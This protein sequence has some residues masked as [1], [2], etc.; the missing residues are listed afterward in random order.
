MRPRPASARLQAQPAPPTNDPIGQFSSEDSDSSSSSTSSASSTSTSASSIARNV[1][2]SAVSLTPAV[3]GTIV[4]KFMD[5][6][7]SAHAAGFLVRALCAVARFTAD[8]LVAMIRAADVSLLRDGE[9][10]EAMGTRLPDAVTIAAV[11]AETPGQNNNFATVLATLKAMHAGRPMTGHEIGR[12]MAPFPQPMQ[13]TAVSA[14]TLELMSAGD[15]GV[16]LAEA[17]DELSWP[18]PVMHQVVSVVCR[19]SALREV[20]D[21][22][23]S[24]YSRNSLR[25][26]EPADG[27][28]AGW[29][30][31]PDPLQLA[32]D[33]P[34]L[35][36][37]ADAA[38]LVARMQAAG[39]EIPPALLARS[40]GEHL[41]DLVSSDEDDEGNLDGFVR[42]SEPED[43][44]DDSNSSSSN[45]SNAGPLLPRRTQP[46]AGQKRP[47][48]TLISSDESEDSG[49][50]SDTSSSASSS[51]ASSSSS[52][53]GTTSSSGPPA[54]SSS[55]SS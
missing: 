22:A 40:K 18:A 14:L 4:A 26:W 39:D 24:L 53:S 35:L 21:H 10:L 32:P 47:R 11:M 51:S 45:S 41:G 25:A 54:S 55:D 36:Q 42:Y 48:P 46:Q 50:E 7:E 31:Q 33:F 8:E 49:S 5:R 29:G 6:A 43:G 2:S 38:V 12:A 27:W 20:D 3:A 23:S 30:V 19:S 34:W 52:G 44:S 13:L 28:P 9:F 15:M 37:P 17:G 16:L 1:A